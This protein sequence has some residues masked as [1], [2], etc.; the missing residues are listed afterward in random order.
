MSLEVMIERPRHDACVNGQEV[1]LKSLPDGVL[2]ERFARERDEASFETLVLRHGPAVLAICRRCLGEDE[3]EDAFQA[4]FIALYGQATRLR[5]AD[6]VA[7]WL[8]CVARRIA[9]RAR[10]R[11]AIRRGR[12]G[13]R[14]EVSDIAGPDD[15][16][17]DFR[18]ILR[19]EVAGLPENYRRAVEL[20]YWQGLNCEQAANRLDCPTGTIKWRLSRAREMLRGRLD[21]IGIT[22]V[23]LFAWL[24]PAPA[25]ASSASTSTVGPPPD[26]GHGSNSGGDG[27]PEDLVRRTVAFAVAIRDRP[28]LLPRGPQWGLPGAPDKGR[29]WRVHLGASLLVFALVFILIAVLPPARK[30]AVAAFVGTSTPPGATACH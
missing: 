13:A 26:R 23:L 27:L 8:G 16:D 9:R 5:D 28:G 1:D 30:Q 2:L 17:D 7:A 15:P 3:A 19:A 18:P 29:G 20:C 21:R 4:T 24:R 10:M 12:E 14:V 22:L 25:S 11:A 6:S